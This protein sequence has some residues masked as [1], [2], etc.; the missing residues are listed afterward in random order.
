MLYM[1]ILSPGPSFFDCG[2]DLIMHKMRFFSD[3]GVSNNECYKFT[4]KQKHL[5]P[6]AQCPIYDKANSFSITVGNIDLWHHVNNR[7]MV[8]LVKETL[9]HSFLDIFSTHQYFMFPKQ[10]QIS[11]DLDY[12]CNE[13]L[14]VIVCLPFLFGETL[15]LLQ[16]DTKDLGLFGVLRRLHKSVLASKEIIQTGVKISKL[17]H[18]ICKLLPARAYSLVFKVPCV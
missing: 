11:I 10:Y 17:N 9:L 8:I 4:F 1:G 16:L 13:I 2:V 6:A 15:V 18:N 3:R 12:F 14:G 7:H 5:F